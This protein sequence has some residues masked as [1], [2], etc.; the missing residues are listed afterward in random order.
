ML[1]ADKMRE[2]LNHNEFSRLNSVGISMPYA[3]VHNNKLD[4]ATVVQEIGKDRIM[5]WDLIRIFL[6]VARSGQ[7]LGAARSLGLD[8]TTVSRRMTSLEARLGAKL[9]ERRT[10][11]CSLTEAGEGF[12]V[13]AERI[14]TEL[15]RAQSELSGQDVA[16]NGTVR[17]GAP[18]GFGT[19]V[20]ARHLPAFL[21]QHP[22][23]TVQLVP[24]PRAFSLAKREADIAVTIEPPVEGKLAIRKLTD[25][26]LSLYASRSYLAESPT[27]NRIEDVVAHRIV[28]YVRDLLFTDALDY[29]GELKITPERRFECAGMIGQ[30]EAVKAGAGVGVLHDYVVRDDPALQRILPEHAVHRAY[31]IVTH[32]D[33]RDLARVRLV[34]DFIVDVTTRMRA[35]FA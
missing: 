5:D 35:R 1:A 3:I 25:Y 28:T 18:D 16:I 27:I 7:M 34:H 24:L 21:D 6:A 15:L 8:H 20:L 4:C 26:R 30:I 11:G 31:W 29:L 17:V 33:V 2:F 12:L 14:E 10:S 9:V 22:G 19:Y 23:L 13:T 32:E